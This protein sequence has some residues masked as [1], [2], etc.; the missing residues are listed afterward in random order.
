MNSLKLLLSTLFVF[1]LTGTNQC[2]AG[3][4]ERLAKLLEA[5]FQQ[6]LNLGWAYESAEHSGKP[7][8][9]GTVNIRT[10]DPFATVH[11]DGFDSF[12]VVPNAKMKGTAV[13]NAVDGR[14]KVEFTD[15]NGITFL[16]AFDGEKYISTVP[17]TNREGSPASSL[18]EVSA[19][20]R[21]G[22]FH[23]A[24]LI[25]SGYHYSP[26]RIPQLANC[27]RSS[28]FS[29]SVPEFL[30]VLKSNDLRHKVQPVDGSNIA[31][32]FPGYF[33][34]KEIGSVV[35]TFNLEHAA[36]LEN[37]EWISKVGWSAQESIEFLNTPSLLG[38][39]FPQEARKVN[40]SSARGTK[41]TFYDWKKANESGLEVEIPD[42]AIVQDHVRMLAYSESGGPVNEARSSKQYAQ[43]Y[44]LVGLPF[45]ISRKPYV[46][47]GIVSVG[48]ILIIWILYRKKRLR[49]TVAIY[50]LISAV[51]GCNSSIET[52]PPYASQHPPSQFRVKW[53][54]GWKVDLGLK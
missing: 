43:Q 27:F 46:I 24:G 25:A 6:L 36:S 26:I 40:W 50:F 45:A 9:W 31:V 38:L 8:D 21:A 18:V 16:V 49:E 1:A 10:T 44:E 32:E 22:T 20:A 34:D 7:V 54:D 19:A 48:L 41:F 12:R 14:L 2:N 33:D 5:R 30:A 52:D 39:Y 28:E 15:P 23:D 53:D 4:T 17:M 37:V 29:I 42:G 35:Y 51:S 3:D 47:L 11:E 13:A